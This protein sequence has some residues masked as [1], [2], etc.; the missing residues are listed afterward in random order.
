MDFRQVGS[1]YVNVL[2]RLLSRFEGT[3]ICNVTYS[4]FPNGCTYTET[5]ESD[6]DMDGIVTISL[7]T[8]FEHNT[9][10]L[11][12]TLAVGE[13][14]NVAVRGIFKTGIPVCRFCKLHKTSIVL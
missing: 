4:I 11:V 8:V 9:T 5:S 7:T 10:L 2:C 3:A 12:E 13:N 14:Q 1:G 6:I